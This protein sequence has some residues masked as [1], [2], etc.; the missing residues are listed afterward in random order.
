MCKWS[1]LVVIT[2]RL[3]CGLIKKFPTILFFLVNK[4]AL[5]VG[6]GG[7]MTLDLHVHAWILASC[8]D[9]SIAGN[10]PKLL[11]VRVGCVTSIMTQKFEQRIF[12][13]FCHK[14]GHSSSETYDM[15]Q[16]AFGNE[17]MGYTQVKEWFCSSKEGQT[18][19]Q[20]DEF[21][22]RSSIKWNQ[23]MIEKCILPC[24]ITGE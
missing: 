18:S 12:V 1:C 13:K 2:T 16:K 19:V 23:M 4:K 21:S 14:L 6:N 15:I 7:P 17:A 10:Y 11:V 24:W 5:G 20:S 8:L 9:C 3:L 22:G